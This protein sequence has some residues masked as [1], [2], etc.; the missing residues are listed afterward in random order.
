MLSL[1]CVDSQAN[2]TSGTIRGGWSVLGKTNQ[3]KS[4]NENADVKMD[5]S[6]CSV[7]VFSL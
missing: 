1:D 7:G 5:F 6:G 2:L 4:C 3:K